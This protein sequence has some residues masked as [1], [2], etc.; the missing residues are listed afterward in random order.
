[1]QKRSPSSTSR[2]HSVLPEKIIATLTI[3]ARVTTALS[4]S[5][6]HILVVET[7]KAATYD[8][9]DGSVLNVISSN[10]SFEFPRPVLMSPRRQPVLA[11]HGAFQLYTTDGIMMENVPTAGGAYFIFGL[12]TN[13]KYDPQREFWP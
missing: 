5:G 12:S 9:V 13:L 6:H 3:L 7:D 8:L 10:D 4:E 1:L 2:E 11:V